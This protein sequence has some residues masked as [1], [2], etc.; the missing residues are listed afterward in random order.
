MRQQHAENGAPGNGV[1][2][3]YPA[4][5]ANDLGHQR[6]AKSGAVHLGGDEGIENIRQKIGRYAR[7]IVAHRDFQ[8]QRDALRPPARRRI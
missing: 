3:D 4:M 1:A 5:V 2:F 7:A 8:R 6:Q